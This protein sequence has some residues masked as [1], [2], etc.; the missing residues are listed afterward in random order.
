MDLENIM[1]SRISQM[2]SQEPHDFTNMWDMKQKATNKTGKQKLI[3]RQQY[4]GFW[5]ERGRGRGRRG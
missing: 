2:V 1:L 3:D 4:G 5:M